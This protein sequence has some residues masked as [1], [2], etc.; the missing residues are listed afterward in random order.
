MCVQELFLNYHG[1]IRYEF[2]VLGISRLHIFEHEGGI[3][4]RDGDIYLYRQ[5]TSG[6]GLHNN[7]A[8]AGFWQEWDC[9][10]FYWGRD[11]Q[12]PGCKLHNSI[13]I[14]VDEIDVF[15]VWLYKNVVYHVVWWFIKNLICMNG[16]ELYVG[17]P[18]F[19]VSWFNPLVVLG[20]KLR[21][22]SR[23]EGF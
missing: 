10:Y 7:H 18:P 22:F 1:M 14:W 4:S 16:T 3:P 21:P 6:S 12:H 19:N 9:S 5:N 8:L 23:M 20:F 15:V 2:Y 11:G 17:E 13:H